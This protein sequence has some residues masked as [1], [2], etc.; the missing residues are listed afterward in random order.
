MVAGFK[1][2]SLFNLT[3]A[4]ITVGDVEFFKRGNDDYP[5]GPYFTHYF[6]NIFFETMR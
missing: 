5:E 4:I 2:C 3:W 1:M 6:E